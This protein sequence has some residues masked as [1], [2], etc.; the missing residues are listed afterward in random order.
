MGPSSGLM[1]T[2]GMSL[3]ECGDELILLAS[4]MLSACTVFDLL[5]RN[6]VT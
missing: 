4:D 1:A 2:P 3:T 6:L 5:L